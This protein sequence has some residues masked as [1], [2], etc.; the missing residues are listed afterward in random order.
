LVFTILEH[1]TVDCITTNVP[2]AIRVG[3]K[4]F[5]CT[6]KL[7][8]T[9]TVVN[10][11]QSKVS[12][13]PKKPKV[14]SVNVELYSASYEFFGRI[15][16]NPTK[17]ISMDVSPMTTTP[18]ATTKST[19]WNP[20]TTTNMPGTT[21]PSNQTSGPEEVEFKEL[22]RNI[23][24]VIKPQYRHFCGIEPIE[25]NM[26]RMDK[27]YT[28]MSSDQFWDN[29]VVPWSFVSTGD[30]FAKYAVHTNANTGLTKDDVETVMAAMKQIEDATCIKF[31]LV[32]PVKGQPWLFIARDARAS[33]FAC[34]LQYAQSTLVGQDIE[35]LGDIYGRFRWAGDQCFSG[36]YAWYGQDSPQNF[37]IS[38]TSLS[39]DQQNDIGLVVHEILHNL[40]LGHTQKRQDAAENIEI[41]WSNINSGSHSQY[42]ACIEANDFSCSRYNHYGTPY[43]CMSIMH[44]RDYFF[45]TPEAAR[46]GGKTMVAK[47]PGCDLSS[48]ASVLSNADIEILNKMYC[49]DRPQATVIMSTNHPSNYPD[50]ENKEYPVSVSDGNVIEL[51]FTAFAIE[52]HESCGYDW[53]MVVDGDGTVLLDKTCGSEKPNKI[54]SKTKSITVKFFSDSSVSLSGFRAEYKAVASAPAP[55]NG[56]WSEWSGF[57]TCNNNR[58]GKSVCRKKKVRYCNNPPASNGGAECAGDSEMFEDCVP[59]WTDPLKNPDCVLHGGWSLWSEASAC[60]SSCTSTRTRTC[61]N[62]MPINSKECEGTAS[63][64][65][66]CTGGD[67]PSVNSGTIKSP[68]HPENYANNEDVRFPL[69]VTAGSTIKLIFSSFDVEDEPNCGY[70]YVKVLDSDG[71]TELAKLCGSS[72]PT[73]IKSTG[74]KMTVIFFTDGSVVKTGFEASWTEEQGETSGEITSP[75]HP[76]VYDNGLNEVKTISVAAGSNV[77]LSV[78]TLSIEEDGGSCPYDHLT[79]YDGPNQG[80]PLLKKLCGFTAPTTPIVSSGN[81]MTLVFTTDGSV[82]FNGFKAQWTQI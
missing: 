4:S 71:S 6:F 5:K 54:T 63:E 36:A 37:V 41:K 32:K 66:D 2:K 45:I 31:N 14:K 77:Q 20:E 24:S 72:L 59:A 25:E 35:G 34:Q 33:D 68:N 57:S 75:N 60:S 70:D 22:Y 42:E 30:D 19:P 51:T 38:Q 3:K 61:T 80:S 43:D 29:A 79:I 44:Y 74:N 17:I 53:L 46:N 40:G 67:C 69:E 82:V 8:H 18:E 1:F 73:T 56:G 23:S 27:S 76:N 81:T 39:K 10:T 58:D 26:R 28:S 7:V 48:P 9:T 15:S 49:G 62:P 52:A 11:K 12:C 78:V 64:T 55:V 65:S 13:S 16:I 47:K 50:N 21:L